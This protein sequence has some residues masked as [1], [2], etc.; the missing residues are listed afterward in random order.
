[1]AG[2]LLGRAE[3]S[4]PEARRARPLA[5]G[6]DGARLRR[7][8]IENPQLNPEDFM[9]LP[10]QSNLASRTGE[11][12]QITFLASYSGGSPEG[13]GAW[14]IQAMN[15]RFTVP[16]NRV[17]MPDA[18]QWVLSPVGGSAVLAR[19]G[20][21]YTGTIPGQIDIRSASQGKQYDS[22]QFHEFIPIG[23]NSQGG[24][25]IDPINGTPQFQT[26]FFFATAFA[27]TVIGLWPVG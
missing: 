23:S 21:V 8:D 13:G 11:T 7:Q 9:P 24:A 4:T 17:A 20:P 16:P 15:F 5:R 22:H 2:L 3:Q 19:N 27:T 12:I 6:V 14:N 26:N 10:G 18:F 1:M 25:L